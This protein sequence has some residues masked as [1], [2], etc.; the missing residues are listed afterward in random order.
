MTQTLLNLGTQPLVNNLC[1]SEQESM[2]AERFPLK[3]IVKE[4]LTIHLDY[5][6]DPEILYKHYLYRSGVSQ[7]YIDHCKQLYKSLYHLNLSTVIDVGGNDGTLLNAFREAS[8]E[9]EFWSG[10]KPTR[11]INV[12]MGQNLREVNEQ[13]GNEFV[14]GQFN[15]QM[16]LPK[17]NLI[18]STNVFQH[19]KDV[20]AFM[21]GIVKFLDGVWVLEFPY[22]LET[23]MTGQFDQFYHEHYYY[24]LI[25]PLEKLFKEYGLKILHYSFQSIHGGTMR[26]WM[27]NKD[28][29]GPAVDLSAIKKKEQ[30]AIGLCNF[31]QT[32][33]DLRSYF[34]RILTTKELGRICFFGAAA[35]G[36]VFLNALDLN[37][38][39]MGKTVVVDDTVEKQGLY[40]PGT[41]FRVVD[42]S[43]LKDYDTVIILAHNFAD[44]IEASLRKDFDGRIVTLLPIANDK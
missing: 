5:A 11:F 25:S 8:T 43:A 15:D 21:R 34:D 13:A 31:D 16:D 42:R 39:T 30:E 40:V 6:V 12:D 17:A 19:T 24:W 32:I 38:N 37:I 9:S 33:A 36:C 18:V 44:Y 4:D 41:G 14:C 20:H 22:T 1:N 2:E 23:I 28:P 10:T 26:L 27:T 7:P 3:A 29:S 35:K